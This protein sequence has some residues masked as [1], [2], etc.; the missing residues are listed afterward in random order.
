MKIITINKAYEFAFENLEQNNFEDLAEGYFSEYSE[1]M[2][3]ANNKESWPVITED[4]DEQ[5]YHRA[6]AE[7]F[8]KQSGEVMPPAIYNR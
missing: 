2:N 6:C 7:K 1:S 8:I 3:F 4:M 5:L